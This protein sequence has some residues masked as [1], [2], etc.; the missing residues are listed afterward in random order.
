MNEVRARIIEN[1]SNRVVPVNSWVATHGVEEKGLAELKLMQKD[2]L[3]EVE[4]IF[5]RRSPTCPVYRLT[6]A[7]LENLFT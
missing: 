3:I 6:P 7:R 4:D 1:L 5:G 2:G